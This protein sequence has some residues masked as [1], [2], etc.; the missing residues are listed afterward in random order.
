MPAARAESS[1]QTQI[2]ERFD[3]ETMAG[4]LM[5]AEHRARYWWASAAV[6]GRDVLD[7]GCGNG[8]GLA[9]LQAA[10]PARLVGVDIAEDAVARARSEV[11]DSTEVVQGDVRDLPFEDDSF[12]VVVCFEV[13]E[14]IEGQ[15]EALVEL[16]RVL[17]PGGLLL[18]SSPNR[19]VY[20]PGNPHHVH[21]FKP[22]EL[23]RALKAH[24]RHVELLQQHPWLTSAITPYEGLAGGGLTQ[25]R[26]GRIEPGLPPGS[27]TYV[28]AIAG[29]DAPSG[30]P[31]VA[32]LGGDFEVSWWQRQVEAM[33]SQR[34]DATKAERQALADAAAARAELGALSRKVLE[35]EQEAA[36]AIELQQTL[37]D[38]ET[39]YEKRVTAAQGDAEYMAGVIRDMKNSISWRVTAPLR[40]LKRLRG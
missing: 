4:G 31:P 39:A 10:G 13:I 18:I 21:E 3:P 22:E 37:D 34:D 12:D 2:P 33:R 29:D 8:Y 26:A 32:V 5:E 15:D 20:T 40:A 27:E 19:G 11:G 9:I 36:R 1:E 16:R 7:A 17:R 24:F 25:V 23:E 28:L 38:L 35:L 6:E 14:H 30:L